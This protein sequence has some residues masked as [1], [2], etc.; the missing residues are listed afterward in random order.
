[1]VVP[2]SSKPHLD[3]ST[4]LEMFMATH[5]LF[6]KSKKSDLVFLGL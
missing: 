3:K 2:K 5:S 1:M 6:M 4:Y